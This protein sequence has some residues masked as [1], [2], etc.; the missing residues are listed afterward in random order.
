MDK[1]RFRRPANGPT[2]TVGVH[3]KNMSFCAKKN[4]KKNPLIISI[5][6]VLTIHFKRHETRHTK[7]R[8]LRILDVL[9][10][11]IFGRTVFQC[12]FSVFHFRLTTALPAFRIPLGFSIGHRCWVT[13]YVF[14]VRQTTQPRTC[15]GCVCA[16]R[17]FP[18][19][20]FG[21][22]RRVVRLV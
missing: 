1:R 14:S 11:T 15:S 7:N 8:T 6:F 3:T 16:R 4:Y 18:Q 13:G 22:A 21:V 10:S 20:F 5:A 17:F 19:K 9:S 2:I 12:C